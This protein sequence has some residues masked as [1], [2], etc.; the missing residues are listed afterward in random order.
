MEEEARRPGEPVLERSIAKPR[1]AG[2]QGGGVTGRMGRRFSV[3]QVRS[4]V[5]RESNYG[6]LL[7]IERT[8]SSAMDLTREQLEQ[9]GS[10]VR[11]HLG[12]WIRVV[13]PPIVARM[14]PEFLERM[15]RIEEELKGQRELMQQGF[16]A[17]ERR[18]EQ[19]DRRFDETR[20][21]MNA[22]FEQVD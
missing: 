20:A 22:R 8:M 18:F 4:I 15:V 17:M 6:R 16:L 5:K 1:G 9:V 3:M 2:C 10:Y 12:T 19:V 7:S 11:E 21:D 13:D 14:E